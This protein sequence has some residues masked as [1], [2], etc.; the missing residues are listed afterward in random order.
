M[1]RI[2]LLLITLPFVSPFTAKGETNPIAVET[3]GLGNTS[4]NDTLTIW[5]VF[6]GKTADLSLRITGE[7]KEK[8]E[9]RDIEL[10]K[11]GLLILTDD[12]LYLMPDMLAR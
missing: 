11:E 8:A 10:T 12:A 2:L 4:K 7:L 6:G 9:I 5:K 1:K 3:T